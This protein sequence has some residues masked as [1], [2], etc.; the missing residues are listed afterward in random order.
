MFKESAFRNETSEG[1]KGGGGGYR[2]RFPCGL[3]KS[4]AVPGSV[5]LCLVCKECYTALF[6]FKIVLLCSTRRGYYSWYSRMIPAPV[7]KKTANDG[8]PQKRY[9]DQKKTGTVLVKITAPARG[10]NNCK[11]LRV[12]RHKYI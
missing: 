6:F 1:R 10:T 5:E 9:N 3:T 11:D 2:C 7:L 12:R 4:T 8:R